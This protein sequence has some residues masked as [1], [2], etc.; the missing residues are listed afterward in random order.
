MRFRLTA[1]IS[2]KRDRNGRLIWIGRMRSTC[3]A[4]PRQ[5]KSL[6]GSAATKSVGSIRSRIIFGDFAA[7]RFDAAST[8]EIVAPPQHCFALS[9]APAEAVDDVLPARLIGVEKSAFDLGP[10]SLR[11]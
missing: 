10:K 3:I 1:A 6:P 9:K 5:M 4:F 7:E 11:P 2:C 8:L